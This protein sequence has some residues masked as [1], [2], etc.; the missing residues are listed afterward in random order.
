[1]EVLEDLIKCLGK[2]KRAQNGAKTGKCFTKCFT[3]FYQNAKV[4]KHL[5]KHP[6]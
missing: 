2:R 4:G 3:M 5:V 1:M 6:R